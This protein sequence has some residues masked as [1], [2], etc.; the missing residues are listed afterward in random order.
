MRTAVV[1]LFVPLVGLAA[2]VPKETAGQKLAKVFG[3]PVD[4]NKDCKFAFD[5]KKL[6][7][8]VGKGDHG[9]H[10]AG[11]RT[12][13]P[14]TL[15]AVEGDFAVEVTATPGD[16]PPGA[17]PAVPGHGFTF[18]SQG[19]LFW[20]D[21]RTYIRLE[22]ARRDP[23]N[24]AVVTYVNWELFKDGQWLRAGGTADGLLD[25]TKPTRF[26]LTRKGNEVRGAWSQDGRKTWNELA[27]ITLD[28][29]AKAQVGVIA[30]H[31]TDA[32][33]AATFEGFAL[34]PATDAKK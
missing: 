18:H 24:G 29:K 28:L 30:A 16:R 19:L 23:P 10:V 8:D 9:M 31:N 5:G 1:V 14:R 22:H 2:P 4:P 26:R 15:R 13:A 21:D 27:A 20:V 25:D 6:T 17:K 12:G 33:F 11:N 34:T 32:P 3:T 7:V